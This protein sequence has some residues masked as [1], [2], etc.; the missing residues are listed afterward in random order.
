MPS[1]LGPPRTEHSM[2]GLIQ[3]EHP[4]LGLPQT[5]HLD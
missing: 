3:T 5:E 2:P 4:R 1:R